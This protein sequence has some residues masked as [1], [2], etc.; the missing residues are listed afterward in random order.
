MVKGAKNYFGEFA[1]GAEWS[2][3]NEVSFRWLGSR[4]RLR[5]LEALGFFIAKFVFSYFSWYFLCY[6]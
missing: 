3:M 2:H 4:A 5:A 1:D 6:F